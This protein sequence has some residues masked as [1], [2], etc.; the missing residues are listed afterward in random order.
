MRT[1]EE[2]QRDRFQHHPDR[3]AAY[4]RAALDPDSADIRAQMVRSV[5]AARGSL[6]GMGL[7]PI[8]IQQ[9]LA[10]QADQYRY[11]AIFSEED[12]GYIARVAEFSLL[13]AFGETEAA[14]LDEIKQ[15]VA[16]VLED[17]HADNEPI[18]APLTQ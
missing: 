7:T 17:L 15:V 5:L 9:L 13:S 10:T 3:A 12:Q 4:A 14:A 16:F 8:E 11:S 2:T 1:Y 18:P 6:D